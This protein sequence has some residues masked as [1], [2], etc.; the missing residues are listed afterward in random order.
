MGERGDPTAEKKASFFFPS[1][2]PCAA[3]WPLVAPAGAGPRVLHPECTRGAS[4]DRLGT[5]AL[6]LPLTRTTHSGQG[7][8]LP[9]CPS[10]PALPPSLCPALGS[11]APQAA[12]RAAPSGGLCLAP[13]RRPSECRL[14]AKPPSLTQP[15]RL[16]AAFAFRLLQLRGRRQF[17]FHPRDSL[18]GW[19]HHHGSS[20]SRCCYSGGSWKWPWERLRAGEGCAPL[21]SR[22]R[23]LSL[24][25][26]LPDLRWAG[27][28]ARGPLVWPGR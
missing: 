17:L 26:A 28:H 16:K 5:C 14:L 3:L 23:L 25:A 27:E 19:G 9:S 20:R 8:R 18:S 4:G 12:T 15:W 1:Q 10:L 22:R 11:R 13:G 24:L 7:R 21:S 6:P 2:A